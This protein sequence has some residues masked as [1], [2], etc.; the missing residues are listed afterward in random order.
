ML[1]GARLTA[2]GHSATPATAQTLNEFHTSSMHGFPLP[3]FPFLPL[4][5]TTAG[6]LCPA[7][8]FTSIS[9]AVRGTCA[10]DKRGAQ[11]QSPAPSG[12]MFKHR[13][14]ECNCF[15]HPF[16][17]VHGI[18]TTKGC[19]GAAL[20]PGGLQNWLLGIR[21]LVSISSGSRLSQFRGLIP[22]AEGMIPLTL[23]SA[24]CARAV[25]S[26]ASW[27]LL[28]ERERSGMGKGLEE[29]E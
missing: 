7:R 25:G 28:P 24:H 9:P 13:R 11:S 8:S 1:Q 21:H 2:L 5:Q 12:V 16:P 4:L 3:S 17:A 15:S 6:T 26:P 22:L 10:A 27:H 14:N 23:S 18:I 29:E 19:C 20:H